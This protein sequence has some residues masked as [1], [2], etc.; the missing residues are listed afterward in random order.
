MFFQIKRQLGK[1]RAGVIQTAHGSIETPVFMPVGTQATVKSLSA[2]DVKKTKAQVILAN[3]YHLFLRPGQAVIESY[4][5]LH[6]FMRWDGPILTDSGGYQVSSLGLFKGDSEVKLAKISDEGVSFI[7]HIDGSKHFMTPKLAI[8][9]QQQLGSDIIMAF[10]EATPSIGKAYAKGAMARTHRWLD[11]SIDEWRRGDEK[12]ALFGIIQGGNYQD[13]RRISAEQIL[14]TPVSG[15]ALGGATIGQSVAQT[16]A[17]AAYVM[18][19]LQDDGRPI[20][21]MGVGVS[22]SHAVGAVL[23]GAD[24]FD[25][26][27]PTKLARCGLL[28]QG[29]LNINRQQIAKSEFISDFPKERINIEKKCFAFDKRPIEENCDCMTCAAGYSRGYL[30][31]LFKA[32]ELLYYRLASIHNVRMM[33]K[34]VEK[35]R[36]AIL[37]EAESIL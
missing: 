18:D 29:Y 10:D 2:E 4:G 12:Q 27:A 14:S 35:M 37:N 11:L 6:E 5:G 33:V 23:A 1:V 13:L 28:Y 24:M 21:F 8:K 22:P 20:Y 26:V 16:A 31:H 9:T 30:H 25:C 19:L 32:R 15:I 34:T 36:L 3:N 17:N 7:S